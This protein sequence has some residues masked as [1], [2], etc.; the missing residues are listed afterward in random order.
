MITDAGK[1]VVVTGSNGGIGTA[2][3]DLL[4]THGYFCIGLDQNSDSLND[5][6]VYIELDLNK[7]V[8]SN[9]IRSKFMETLD[10]LAGNR[11]MVALVN[12]A[13]TQ[14]T[15]PFSEIQ[16]EDITDSFNVNVFAPLIL[17]QLLLQPLSK[18]KGTI[19]NIGSIHSEQTKSGFTTYAMTKSALSSL[20]RSLAL[21]VGS[22]ITVNEVAPA[23]IATNMLISGFKDDPEGLSQLASFHPVNR[24]GQPEEVAKLVH[25]LILNRSGFINGARF[26]LD[27][28]ISSKLSDPK[29]A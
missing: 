21:E 22:Q 24:I 7:L 26:S 18:S 11:T 12:N 17:S 23:A 10:E 1:A 6:D 14:N 8:Q 16:F 13:A 2:I 19:V 15:A 5:A 27:G 20:T 28:G 3:I 25:F 29:K 4:H 9:E